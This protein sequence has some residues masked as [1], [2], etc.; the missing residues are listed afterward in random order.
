M[1]TKNRK[2]NS[3]RLNVFS[4]LVPCHGW[5]ED[6]VRAIAFTGI[7]PGFQADFTDYDQNS[8]SSEN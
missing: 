1:E 2:G 7:S 8:V 4:F 5:N 6:S 3:Q